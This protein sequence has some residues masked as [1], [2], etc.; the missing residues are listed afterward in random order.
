MKRFHAPHVLDLLDLARLDAGTLELQRLP[1]TCC[2][3]QTVSPRNSP[4]RP[5]LRAVHP[6]GLP[7]LPPVTGDGDRLAQVFTNLVDNAL[8]HTSA[9][10]TVMLRARW[11]ALDY[12][13]GRPC[14]C[15]RK[16]SGDP[17]GSGR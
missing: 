11:L 2:P 9:G 12:A 10:G 17:G 8:K 1:W 5:R 15:T 6:R 7:G 16:S 13:R 3:A 14:D 4:R